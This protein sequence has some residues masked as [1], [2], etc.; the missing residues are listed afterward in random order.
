M[1]WIEEVEIAKSIDDLMTSQSISGRR[2]FP[3]YE[4]LDAV[5]APALKKL[6]TSVH[7]RKRESV[8]EQRAQK[9]RPI[10]ARS[11]TSSK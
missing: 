3:D 1:H 10:L 6:L 11:S 2:D 4:M 7:F 5:I 9:R 8:E